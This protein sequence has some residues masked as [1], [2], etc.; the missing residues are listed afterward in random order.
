MIKF[1]LHPNIFEHVKYSKRLKL[2]LVPLEYWKV[3]FA[4]FMFFFFEQYFLIIIKKGKALT[5]GKYTRADAICNVHVNLCL[6]QH[7]QMPSIKP[8]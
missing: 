2:K 8:H 7:D 4:M 6:M 1:L 3:S 5:H